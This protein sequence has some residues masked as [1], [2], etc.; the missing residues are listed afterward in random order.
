MSL[1]REVFLRA[2]EITDA[3]QREDYLE[4]ACPDAEFRA[5]IEAMLAFD[6]DETFLHEKALPPPQTS[7]IET[8][9]R[10]R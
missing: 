9:A 8:Y 7:T 4:A 6:P 3:R 1:D 5:R 2:S 10:L